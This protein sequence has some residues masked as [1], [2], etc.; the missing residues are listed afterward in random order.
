MFCGKCGASISDTGKFCPKCGTPVSLSARTP[1]Q[2]I[3]TRVNQQWGP[4]PHKRMIPGRTNNNNSNNMAVA[5]LVLGI[6]A[7]SYC[8][9]PVVGSVVGILAI[10]FFVLSC[11]NPAKRGLGIAG[12]ILGI[13]AIVFAIILHTE[14]F[15]TM[16]LQWLVSVTRQLF[17][18]QYAEIMFG[19]MFGE[20]YADMLN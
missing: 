17:G 2:N 10:V 15:Q 7:V 19:D 18:D 1:R 3:E 13:I 5:S 20:Q 9:I 11:K 8:C 14:W 6:I 4:K 16:L 12:L